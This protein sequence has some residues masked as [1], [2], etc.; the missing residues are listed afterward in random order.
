MLL[1]RRNHAPNL[2][3]DASTIDRDAAPR[4][5][6]RSLRSRDQLLQP[7]VHFGWSWWS[8]GN[9]IEHRPDDGWRDHDRID[10][11][12]IDLVDR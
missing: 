7:G 11:G 3:R 10:D 2:A 6:D 5:P 9:D 12:R 1:N 8:R 4:P